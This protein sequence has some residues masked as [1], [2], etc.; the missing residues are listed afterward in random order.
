MTINDSATTT[1]ANNQFA[2]AKAD[3]VTLKAI[4][5][6]HPYKAGDGVFLARVMLQYYPDNKLT[7]SSSRLANDNVATEIAEQ[8][9]IHAYPNPSKGELNISFNQTDG[10]YYTLELVNLL[11]RTIYKK[12][13]AANSNVVAIS[14]N[15][16]A[17]GVYI[18]RISNSNNINLY[19]DKLII[20]T[21]VTQK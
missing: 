6:Q 5:I 2:L 13:L 4:A 1:W 15:D 10:N 7:T 19:S 12:V 14:L 17:N 9:E 3:S 18:C 21:D 16:V 20:I 11:G 8:Q